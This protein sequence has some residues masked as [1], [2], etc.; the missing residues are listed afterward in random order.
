MTS[1]IVEVA[2]LHKSFTV[3]G[4]DGAREELHAVEGVDLVLE[5]GGSLAVVG[6][7]GSGKTTT[8]RII[9][10]L[11]KATSGSITV[12][13]Q[14]WTRPAR[15]RAER[16]ARSRL[17]Q[18]VFQD[19]FGSLDPRQR[20]GAGLSE[21]LAMHFDV[22]R[23]T[24]RARVAEA[25]ERVGLD[26]SHAQA[27]PRRLSGGQRQ[28][29][30]IARAL[31]LRPRVLILDE[32]VSALDVSVQAQ[33]LTLLNEIRD[34]LDVAYLFVSHDLAVVRQVCD[35]CVVMRHGQVVERGEVAGVL[36]APQHPYTQD[37]LDAV[38]RPGWKPS[39]SRDRRPAVDEPV[40]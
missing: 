26:A 13:G 40:P 32:A 30:A 5:P 36:D 23:T 6:E 17:V 3:V 4:D 35:T 12:A 33:V 39:R 18:M 9:A 34:T 19:P 28:R 27:Y 14:D 15:G 20:I 37:L 29:V 10:G 38:P 22:G 25:L 16:L 2:G 31:V 24:A 1:P 11:G 7:S 21:L 8:A